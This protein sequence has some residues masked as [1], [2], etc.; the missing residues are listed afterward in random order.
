M[1][2]QLERTRT[3]VSEAILPK[4][5]HDRRADAKTRHDFK[6]QFAIILGFSELLLENMG[7]DDPRKPDVVEVRAATL[8]ALQMVRALCL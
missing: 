3:L 2:P 1:D 6:N 4:T 7:D 5:D 8:N